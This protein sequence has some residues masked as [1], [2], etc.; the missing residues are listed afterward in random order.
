MSVMEYAQARIQ[1]RFGA[2][3]QPELWRSLDTAPD[4]RT[5]LDAARG[6]SLAP[7][8]N[9]IEPGADL[10]RIDAALRARLEGHIAEVAR[11]LPREWNA[12]VL[13]LLRLF[14]LPAIQ[15][16]P[17][18][19]APGFLRRHR[20]GV[21][22]AARPGDVRAAFL[23]EWKRR[24][25]ARDPESLSGMQRIAAAVAGHLERFPRAGVRGASQ[26]RGRLERELRGLFRN[27]AL[28][29]D[30]AFC[31]LALVALDL[32]RLRAVLVLRALRED[33]ASP[34]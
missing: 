21:R 31:H 23:E 26:E 4:L 12:A 33:E 16:L 30:A 24:W 3:P 32:E 18:G 22:G 7:W 19:D 5:Y 34:A 1:A 13:W 14:E 15:H 2:R 29:P 9:G 17:L 8:T 20:K 6:T 27:S 25:P 11:W 10:H 28:R